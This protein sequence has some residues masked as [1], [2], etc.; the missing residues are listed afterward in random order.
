[1]ATRGLGP[2][3]RDNASAASLFPAPTLVDSHSDVGTFERLNCPRTQLLATQGTLEKSGRGRDG[4]CVCEDGH[5][6]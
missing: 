2:S 4:F 3:G 1:M 5:A 6:L